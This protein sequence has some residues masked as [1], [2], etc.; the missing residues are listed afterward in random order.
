M[1]TRE[2]PTRP[3]GRSKRMASASVVLL[4]SASEQLAERCRRLVFVEGAD[5]LACDLVSLRGSAAWLNPL[6]IVMTQDVKAFDP[7][8]FVELSRRIGAELVV[9]PSEG[10]SDTQLTAMITAALDIAQRRRAD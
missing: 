6:A 10:V 8:G 7:E 2:Q 4:V 5:L 9:L 1:T 3:A